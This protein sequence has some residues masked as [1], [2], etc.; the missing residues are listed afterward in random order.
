MRTAEALSFQHAADG[1]TSLLH[2]AVAHEEL[3]DEAGAAAAAAAGGRLTSAED[4]FLHVGYDGAVFGAE[5]VFDADVTRAASAR[6]TSP[7]LVLA[8]E[9]DVD[10]PPE[11]MAEHA[12]LLPGGELV[13]QP[14]AD[15]SPGWTVP[16]SSSLWP[17]GTSRVQGVV[18]SSVVRGGGGRSSRASATGRHPKGL[19]GRPSRAAATAWVYTTCRDV[20][21]RSRDV[22]SKPWSG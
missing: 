8:G 13:V 22:Q 1:T 18:A 2:A 14:A 5:G 19:P 16:I 15:T 17:R 20:T 9:F 12:E 7:V 21:M 6:F 4:G 10:P 3:A 11:A